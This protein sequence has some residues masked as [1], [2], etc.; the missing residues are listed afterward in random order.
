MKHT[1][2]IIVGVVSLLVV[3]TLYVLL[4]NKEPVIEIVPETI[5]E[6]EVVPE[7]PTTTHSVIGKSVQGREIETYTI[8]TGDTDLLFVGGMHGG[9]E[10][11]SILL[12]Y[13]MI[14][15]FENNLSVIPDNVKVHII[16]NLN[17]DGL[18]LATGLE[19]RFEATDISSNAMHTSGAGR[20]NAN[21]VDLN[22]NFDC[23]W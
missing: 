5:V 13:E 18:F 20:F 21:D 15:Y 9:Y 23:K 12:A 14:D 3:G 17:P 8:G 16:P 11:N 19:R 1:T 10:W 22:R 4:T 6:P 2:K 7:I